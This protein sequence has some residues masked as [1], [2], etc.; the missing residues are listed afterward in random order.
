VFGS[1]GFGAALL[2]LLPPVTYSAASTWSS[3]NAPLLL[4]TAPAACVKPAADFALALL[5][6]LVPLC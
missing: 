6:L 4:C 1:A 5:L 2:L 3:P